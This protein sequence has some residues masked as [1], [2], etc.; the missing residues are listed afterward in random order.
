MSLTVSFVKQDGV[1][2]SCYVSQREIHTEVP[3]VGWIC[4]SVLLSGTRFL[5]G[6][7]QNLTVACAVLVVVVIKNNPNTPNKRN[8]SLVVDGLTWL[9]AIL[10]RYNKLIRSYRIDPI[11]FL[12]QSK[13]LQKSTGNQKRRVLEV[14]SCM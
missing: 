3:R 14:G 1:P 9:T 12:S 4:L 10:L 5:A 2:N 7:R 6:N 8:S 13:H 11:S